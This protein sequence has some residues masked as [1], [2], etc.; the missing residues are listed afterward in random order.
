MGFQGLGTTRSPLSL[1]DSSR[2]ELQESFR[3]AKATDERLFLRSTSSPVNVEW[4]VI[5][6]T[7]GTSLSLSAMGPCE[8]GQVLI[9]AALS[10]ACSCA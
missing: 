4:V 3:Q 5:D 8:P 10:N 7:G 2:E 1:D 6:E 9:E